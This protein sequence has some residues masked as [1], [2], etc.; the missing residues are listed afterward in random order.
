MA[1]SETPRNL[2]FLIAVDRSPAA[3]P[4]VAFGVRLG[5]ALDAK[6]TLYHALPPHQVFV[7]AVVDPTDAP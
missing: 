5:N 7:N 2:Q 1:S 6:V 4:H 3:E